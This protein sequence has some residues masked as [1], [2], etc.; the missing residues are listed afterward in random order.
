MF[1]LFN[2]QIWWPAGKNNFSWT[3]E[4]CRIT[5]E[6]ERI[7]LCPVF[8]FHAA[9]GSAVISVA[10]SCSVSRFV[11]LRMLFSV[12]LFNLIIWL[13][14][15]NEEFMERPQVHG[16]E[17]KTLLLQRILEFQQNT[18]RKLMVSFIFFSCLYFKKL[19]EIPF[20]K[21]VYDF[22]SL[23]LL[24]WDGIQFSDQIFQLLTHIPFLPYPGLF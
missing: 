24:T 21:V 20:F 11:E 17:G 3:T 19:S 4:S 14:H 8:A 12:L 16:R 23:Y 13:C 9:H 7:S 6:Q 1:Y 10:L 5:T 18:G 2:I 22:L 15:Q